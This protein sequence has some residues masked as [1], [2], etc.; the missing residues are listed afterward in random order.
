VR[1]LQ[2]FAVAL[3][4]LAL[5]EELDEHRDLRPQDLGRERLEDVVDGPHRVAAEHV[6]V[7]AVIG[8]QED[9][10]RVARALALADER[11]GLVAVEVRHRDVEQD[12]REVAGEDLA[13]R[14]ATRRRANEPV[15]RIREDRF[16]RQ[17]VLLVVVHE[18]DVHRPGHARVPLTRLTR[19]S[20]I[21]SIGRM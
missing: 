6:N 9:D 4:R 15:R 14:G 3:E 1:K 21:R 11:G 7:A 20:P 8:G 16:E 5:G 18:Q 17:Q 12:Q 13:Q 10:R 19:C 2:R